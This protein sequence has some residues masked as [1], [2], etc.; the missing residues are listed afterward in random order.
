MKGVVVVVNLRTPPPPPILKF[1]GSKTHSFP[2][3]GHIQNLFSF[4]LIQSAFVYQIS[5]HHHLTLVVSGFFFMVTS[6]K[7]K[8]K[9]CVT[10]SLFLVEK[11]LPNCLRKKNYL[12]SVLLLLRTPSDNHFFFSPYVFIWFSIFHHYLCQCQ[13]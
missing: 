7:V 1:L 11:K 5:H 9:N 10:N 8:L 6:K 3:V 2:V 13:I 4:I 12:D